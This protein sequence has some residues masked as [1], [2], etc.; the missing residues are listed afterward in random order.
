MTRRVALAS[1]IGTTIEWYDFLI[2][3]TAASLV[4]GRL[5]FPSDAG[6]TS[7]LLAIST[8]GVGFLI[9]PLGAVILSNLGDR[10]G[11]RAMLVGTLSAMGVATTLIG[12]LPTYAQ[13]GVAAPIMLVALRLVQGFAV[14]GEWGGAVL[15][16]VEHAPRGRRGFYGSVVQVGFPVGLGL[17]TFS[18]FLL[19]LLPDEQFLAWG[20]RLP[21]LLS[22]VLVSVGLFIRLRVPESPEFERARNSGELVRFPVWQAVRR[23]P[24]SVLIGLGVRLTELSWI[25]VL[26][27]FAL[28]YATHTLGIPRDLVLAAIAAGALLELVTVPLFGAVS[29][30]VGR[31]PIY[32]AGSVA[33][34]ALAF[35]VFWAIDSGDPIAVVCA[36]ALGMAVGHGVMYG[37]QASFLAELFGA[38]V[39]YSGA[40][41]G[42][43]LAAPIGGGLVPVVATYLVADAGGKTWP[44]SLMMIGFAAVT[45]AAVWVARE[46]AHGTESTST[47]PEQAWAERQGELEAS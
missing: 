25:Y 38:N 22:A 3:A 45:I 47:A 43:Q 36:F 42:Y 21:F 2:Y 33:A 18:F 26:T 4:F 31:R 16:A 40:S 12:L 29:D 19:A 20:W 14:G 7:S 34:A 24:R 1:A 5:F 13:I 17:G 37:V 46:T 28:E 27:V 41:L 9:R 23:H 10:V 8:I 35:P 6:L 32:L 44:V 30:R 11:R 15:M 39:R